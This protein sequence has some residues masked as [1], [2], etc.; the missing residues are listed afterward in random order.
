M[1]FGTFDLDVISDGTFALDGGAMFGVVPKVF[2]HKV[3]PAD[4]QNRVR[5][6]LNCLVIRAPGLNVLVDT[7][8]G[9][10]FDSK[11]SEI[12]AIRH[13]RHLLAEL[14]KLGLEP[15]DI[16]LV[17]NTHLHFDH[18]GG[19]TRTQEG[20]PVPTFPRAKYVVR[21]GELD[22][23][24][25]ANERTRASYL[26]ENWEPLE[27][28]RQI[29]FVHEN[30]DLHQGISVFLTPG[31]LPFHQSVR[32]ESEGRVAV[33]LGD[34]IPTRHHLPL[35]WIMGYDV[36]PLETLETKRQVL[37]HALEENWLVI[38]EHD[39]QVPMASLRPEGD[40]LVA[41]PASVPF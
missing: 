2:W 1:K 7:G 6:G 36:S 35:P 21:R 5:L 11:Y 9:D 37:R 15:Q 29:E 31:H 17:V 24:K 4:E 10:K 22:F 20:G 13:E 28:S 27:K 14:K 19:N 40:R 32:I 34:L 26:P 12:Y 3:L 41:V 30:C 25:N 33:F 18:A 23:A 38:F 39:H 16:H 8:I